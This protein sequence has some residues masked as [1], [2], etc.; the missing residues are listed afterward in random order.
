M[1]ALRPVRA[2]VA[3]PPGDVLAARHLLLDT[4]LHYSIWKILVN[5]QTR[6]DPLTVLSV[7]CPTPRARI[8]P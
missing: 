3:R 8:K 4:V 5:A 7:T 6:D 2:R 1:Y